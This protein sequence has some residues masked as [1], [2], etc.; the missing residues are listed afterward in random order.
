VTDDLALIVTISGVSA[1]LLE[2]RGEGSSFRLSDEY[3]QTPSRPVLG[4]GFEDD[5]GGE[6]HVRSGVPRWFANLL[7]EGPLLELIADKAGVHKS[8]SLFL[9]AL[10]GR[11]LPGAVEIVG[12]LP[13][14][15]SESLEQI[16]EQ[17]ADLLKFSL[18]GVQLKFSVLKDER[19]LT[20]PAEGRGGHW[21]VKLPDQ[22]FE[23]VP[24]M[25]AF[26]MSW[27]RESGIDVPE[28]SVTPVSKI[29][30][31]P[32]EL[33]DV[34]GN[35]FAVKRF[36]REGDS[37]IHIEDFAQVLGVSPRDKYTGANY[38]TLA[39]VI[40]HLSGIEDLKEFVRRLVFLVAAG[41]GD[42]HL[43]NWSLIYPD[44][45]SARLAPAYDL[46]PTFIFMPKDEKLALNLGGKKRF[47]DI[48]RESFRRF[49]EKAE[50]DVDLV[51]DV[52][53]EQV[54]RV[55]DALQPL[56]KSVLSADHQKLIQGRLKALPLF[57]AIA[58]REKR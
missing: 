13:S 40:Q 14:H 51:L 20:V 47:S 50:I 39:R 9:L 16:V 54:P 53:D 48:S 3:I 27:A 4:Q 26:G 57:S 12:E 35:A 1:G 6:H 42:A 43:K 10:L 32:P 11:D 24:E 44:G 29:A 34:R 25:E 52:V 21:I 38:E 22:R 46:V 7:P 23:G 5:P 56:A 33:E 19:G 28:F 18:A 30:G 49:A 17:E 55:I 36:D 31:L 41:N 2:R 45:R 15:E 8:R 37:R 58:D